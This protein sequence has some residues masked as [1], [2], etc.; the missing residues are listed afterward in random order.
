MIQ[1][2]IVITYVL[3]ISLLLGI[4]VD[5]YAIADLPKENMTMVDNIVGSN[6]TETH[7]L[8]DINASIAIVFATEED[9]TRDFHL[10][11]LASNFQKIVGMHGGIEVDLQENGLNIVIS[12][13]EGIPLELATPE[14]EE[15]LV[16]EEEEE[17]SD[18]ESEEEDSS[19]TPEPPTPQP[20]DEEDKDPAVPPPSPPAPFF[21][22][23]GS[24]FNAPKPP[25]AEPEES[26][27]AEQIA[28][29]ICKPVCSELPFHN[30]SLP[31]TPFPYDYCATGPMKSPDYEKVCEDKGS[32]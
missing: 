3:G 2:L 20:P 14:P 23:G 29:N 21:S 11:K 1:Q 27:E 28:P 24:E 18:S 17:S 9:A 16:R 7:I 6:A 19:G 25:E 10:Q 22:E 30:T 31:P 13:F 32:D 5:A 15:E 26:E 8:S 4:A 12:P